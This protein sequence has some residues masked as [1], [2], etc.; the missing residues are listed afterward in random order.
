MNEFSSFLVKIDSIIATVKTVMLAETFSATL[1]SY[2]AHAAV[3]YWEYIRNIVEDSG[4][5]FYSRVK[6]GAKDVVNSMLNFGY[7]ILYPRIW[8]AILRHGLNPYSGFIHRSE[9]NA[10]LVFDLIELF[11]CQAVDRVV[12]SMIN[13]GEK[14]DVDT[15][16]KLCEYTKASLTRHVLERLE[17]YET[18]R[19]ESRTLNNIIDLQVLDLSRSISDGLPFR[20]YVAK[21]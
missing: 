6:R 13:K 2:E 8:Q 12:V 18:Y 17:R 1:M 11:R 10:N 9:G 14:C 21:W 19:G 16:G 15:D 7:S 3:E 5:E 20:P 4:V